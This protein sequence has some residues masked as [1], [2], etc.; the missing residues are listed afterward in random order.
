MAEQA[1]GIKEFE[2]IGGGTPTISSPNNL[3]LKA[4]TVAISTNISIGGTMSVTGGGAF[5]IGSTVGIGS[6][7]YVSHGDLYLRDNHQLNI[8]NDALTMRGNNGGNSFITNIID[9]SNGSPGNLYIS[10]LLYLQS[11]NIYFIQHSSQ[12][13]LSI[14]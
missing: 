12:Q 5:G 9:T 7:L 14:I 8:N 4:A 6:T 13:K 10:Y 1:F 2:L 3:N 11:S